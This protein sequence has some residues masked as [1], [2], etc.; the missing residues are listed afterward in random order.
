MFHLIGKAAE[1]PLAKTVFVRFYSNKVNDKQE[2]LVLHTY[3]LIKA[4]RFM[5][6]KK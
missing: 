2:K 6:A 5:E 1:E 3:P 4:K